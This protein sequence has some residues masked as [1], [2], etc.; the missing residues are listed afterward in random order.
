MRSNRM[1]AAQT[2]RTLG[3][4]T[5]RRRRAD[6]AAAPRLRAAAAPRRSA[7]APPSEAAAQRPLCACPP[8]DDRGPDHGDTRRGPSV[9]LRTEK[10]VRTEGG[11]APRHSVRRGLSAEGDN[12]SAQRGPAPRHSV[13]RTTQGAA[14]NP[15]GQPPL[16]GQPVGPAVTAPAVVTRSASPRRDAGACAS[17]APRRAS[18][19][20]RPHS[21]PGPVDWAPFGVGSL[22]R[23][24][25]YPAGGRPRR[26]RADGVFRLILHSARDWS[27]PTLRRPAPSAPFSP[28]AA[29]ICCLRLSLLPAFS[30]LRRYLH[31]L[32]SPVCTCLHSLRFLR[33]A[34]ACRTSRSRRRRGT[35]PSPAPARQERL[36]GF[37]E[38]TEMHILSILLLIYYFQSSPA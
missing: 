16:G 14:D 10:L 13:R 11:P 17:A 19:P 23:S 29:D 4:D 5:S 25:H 6:G 18:A 36:C 24:A 8:H 21:A 7:P 33:P 20:S 22:L 3:P 34:R 15:G 2:R 30:S 28:Q 35:A 32:H 12:G 27:A 38:V 1:R 31:P 26:A 9:R 37:R